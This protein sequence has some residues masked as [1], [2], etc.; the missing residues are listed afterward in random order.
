MTSEKTGGSGS[1]NL[2]AMK[3]YL[4]IE[5]YVAFLDC[6]REHIGSGP[7]QTEKDENY[8]NNNDSGSDGR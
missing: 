3:D 7:Y 1:N 2:D 4:G 5:G 6:I 8:M